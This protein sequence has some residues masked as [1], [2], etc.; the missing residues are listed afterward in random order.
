MLMGDGRVG[1][2]VE[3]GPAEL[4][5]HTPEDPRTLAYIRGKMG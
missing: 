2:L 1:E 5:M 4:V 3:T